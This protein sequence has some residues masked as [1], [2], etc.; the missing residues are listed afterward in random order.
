MS[1]SQA[2]LLPALTFRC[3]T[4]AAISLLNWSH[5]DMVNRQP[6]ALVPLLLRTVPEESHMPRT[7]KLEFGF[8]VLW[9]LNHPFPPAPRHKT[10]AQEVTEPRSRDSLAA[11]GHGMLNSPGPSRLQHK[12]R[13]KAT[14]PLLHQAALCG[15]QGCPSFPGS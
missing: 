12:L 1:H 10:Q 2:A 15:V 14:R 7:P 5:N 8:A 6:A 3:S 13:D 4:E 11:A 9:S